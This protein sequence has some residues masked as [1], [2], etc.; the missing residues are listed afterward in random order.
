MIALSVRVIA[1]FLEVT[2]MARGNFLSNR[3][4]HFEGKIA[5]SFYLKIQ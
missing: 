1:L 4:N 5:D 2:G 3:P